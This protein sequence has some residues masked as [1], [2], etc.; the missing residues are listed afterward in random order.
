M[1][2]LIVG[3]GKPLQYLCRRFL[4]KDCRVTLINRDPEE[5]DRLSRDLQ[6]TVVRGDGTDPLLLAEAGVRA[7]DVVLAATPNDPDNLIICQLAARRFSVPHV[8]AVVNDPENEVVFQH[9]GVNAISTTR[10]IAGLIEQRTVFHE[11]ANLIALGEGRVIIT[12]IHLSPDMPAVN[13]FVRG[14]ELPPNALLACVVRQG[15]A[16][17]PRGGTQLMAGDRVLLISLPEN[18]GPALRAITGER[19]ERIR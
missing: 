13:L 17:I 6:A 16:V 4:S 10:V 14:L 11:I 3:G 5:C 15:E 1:N 8:V 2:I 19:R 9:L 7:A 18:H 12:E